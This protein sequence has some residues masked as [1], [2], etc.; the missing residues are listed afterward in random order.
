M[1]EIF[2]ISL[3]YAI[4]LH[5]SGLISQN[6]FCLLNIELIILIFT[7]IILLNATSILLA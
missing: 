7:R 3:K 1:L 4:V 2:I 6:N 5:F